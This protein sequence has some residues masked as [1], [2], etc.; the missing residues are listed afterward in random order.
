MLQSTV[1]SLEDFG[2]LFCRLLPSLPMA[3]DYE[4]KREYPV[5][6]NDSMFYQHEVGKRGTHLVQ[7]LLAP[8]LRI[9]DSTRCVGQPNVYLIQN[10]RYVIEYRHDLGIGNR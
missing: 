5:Y 4:P 7:S 1:N 3:C 6:E 9:L 2:S 10:L 8:L